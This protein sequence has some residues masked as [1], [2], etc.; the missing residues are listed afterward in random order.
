MRKPGNGKVSAFDRRQLEKFRQRLLQR[1]EE[2]RQMLAG[3]L[4]NL[5]SAQ[6]EVRGELA[7]AALD[8]GTLEMSYRTVEIAGQE[9]ALIERALR[10]IAQGRY[11]WCEN[12]GRK[13]T[14]A[15]LQAL[16]HALYCVACQRLLENSGA[17][18]DKLDALWERVLEMEQVENEPDVDLT[19]LE[20]D[21]ES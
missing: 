13:I 7:D 3:R 2:L 14:A 19:E 16:P 6:G 9:L 11:G 4:E 1:Q 8:F 20:A 12:C 5:A 21:T 17:C 15:R 10:K 18:D